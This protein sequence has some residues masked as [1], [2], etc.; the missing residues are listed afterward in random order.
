[1]VIDQLRLEKKLGIWTLFLLYYYELYFFEENY[2]E[3]YFFIE[4]YFFEENYYEIYYSCFFVST[5]LQMH[6]HSDKIIYL[7]SLEVLK[8]SILLIN[9]V[10]WVVTKR[11]KKGNSPCSVTLNNGI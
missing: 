10:E 4:L 8:C 9:F 5:A 3:I 2:Y 7:L 1:M 11:T 6:I